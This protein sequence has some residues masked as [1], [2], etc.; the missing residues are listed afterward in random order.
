MVSVCN[1]FETTTFLYTRCWYTPYSIKIT[2]LEYSFTFSIVTGTPYTLSLGYVFVEHL[3]G[4]GGLYSRQRFE[5]WIYKSKCILGHIWVIS[6]MRGE[7]YL[8]LYIHLYKYTSID[9]I[10]MLTHYNKNQYTLHTQPKTLVIWAGKPLYVS[11]AL[12]YV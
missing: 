6:I 3:G 11:L 12:E 10:A 5:P 7:I 9:S 8:V 2:F 1:H 4:G